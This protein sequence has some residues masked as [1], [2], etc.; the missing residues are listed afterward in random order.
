MKLKSVAEALQC[1]VGH[2]G[3]GG[4]YI[5]EIVHSHGYLINVACVLGIKKDIRQISTHRAYGH[6]VGKLCYEIGE[7]GNMVVR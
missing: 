3:G 6:A 4:Y 2:G 5:P 1:S 7:V